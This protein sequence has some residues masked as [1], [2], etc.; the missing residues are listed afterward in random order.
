M[1]EIEK[2]LKSL[3]FGDDFILEV[4]EYDNPDYFDNDIHLIEY[5]AEDDSYF[6]NSAF[7]RTDSQ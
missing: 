4:Q 1:S 3:D 7:I 6:S 2:I 5:D